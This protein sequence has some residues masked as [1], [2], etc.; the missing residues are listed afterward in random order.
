MGDSAARIA[1]VGMA[2]RFPGAANAE[3]FWANLIAGRESIERLTVEQMRPHEPDIDALMED[4]NFV[5]A[6]GMLDDIELFDAGFFG[7]SP[8]EAAVLDPQQRLWLETAWSALEQAGVDPQRFKGPIGVFAGAGNMEQ[9][10]LYNML[11]DR[12]GVENQVKLRTPEA[13]SAMISSGKDFLP[14]RTAYKFNLRGPAVNVQT[15]CSTAL[16]AVHMACQSLLAFESDLAIAGGVSIGFPQAQGYLAQ[17]GGIR[18]LDGHCRA[19]DEKA[20]GTVFSSGLGAFVLKRMEDAIDDGDEILAVVR[21]SALNNDGADKVSYGAPSPAGQAEV[22]AMAQAMADVHPDE[23]GYIEAHGTATPLG[24]PIE[25]EG[26]TRAWR[27]KSTATGAV[28]LG[29]VKSNVGHLDAAAGAAGLVKAVYALREGRLPATL[30]YQRP[31][32]RIDFDASPFR[33]VS[34]LTDW[35]AQASPD[36]LRLAGVS[37]FGVGGTNAHLIVEQAPER[38]AASPPIRASQLLVLSAKSATALARRCD[39]LADWL[40][41]NDNVELADVAWTLATGRAAMGFRTFVVAHSVAQAVDA[42]RATAKTALKRGPTEA[43][44][45]PLVFLFP[46]QGA[47]HPGMGRALYDTPGV[48]RD[49]VDRLAAYLQP[50]LELDIRDLLYPADEQADDQA[51]SDAAAAL[52]NTGVAQPALFVVQ[53]ALARLWESWGVRPQA[54]LGHSVGEYVAA[55]LAD[56][57]TEEQ[58]CRVLACRARFM[59]RMPG[60]SMLAIRRAEADMTPLLSDDIALAAVN[61]P[62]LCIVSGPDAA[63]DA[64]AE[65]LAADGEQSIRLHTSHAFHSAMMDGAL[66]PFEAVIAEHELGAPARPFV[67]CLTGDWITPEQA[68]DASY[69]SGQ[70]RQT[71]RFSPALGRLLEDPARIYIECGPSQNLTAAVRQH[72]KAGH[73]PVCIPS[74]AHAAS[75]EAADTALLS[76]L[77][78]LWQA[79]TTP[80]WAAVCGHARTPRQMLHLPTYP[81]ERQRYWIDP[82]ARQPRSDAAA[83]A[84]STVANAVPLQQTSVAVSASDKSV[85]APTRQAH[86]TELLR[87]L[88]L[89]L[90]G[91][92]IDAD[93]EATA[94]AALGMDSLFL[95]QAAAEISTRFDT[96]VRFRQLLDDIDSLTLLAT[97]LDTTLDADRFQP[98]PEQPSQDS[99]I[100][101]PALADAVASALPVPATASAAHGPGS[102]VHELVEQQ[103]DIMRRQLALLGG[104]ASA[105]HTNIASSGHGAGAGAADGPTIQAQVAQGSQGQNLAATAPGRFGPYKSINQDRDGGLTAVQQTFL[106][107]LIATLTAK[108]AKSKQASAAARKHLADPRGVAN[109]RRSWK[110]LVYQIVADRTDGARMVD[111]D[112]NAYVDI[113]MGFGVGFMGH[114]HP[115][116]VD[117][118]KAQIDKG[119]EVGPQTPLAPAV[120]EKFC[121]LVG[122]ERVTFCNTGSEAVMAALRCARTVTGRTKVVYFTGDYHGTFDEVLGRANIVKDQLT[123]RP[124]APGLAQ[125]S[126]DNVMVLDYGS[127]ASLDIVRAQADQIA[128]VLVEPVQSRYPDLQPDAFVRALRQITADAG[129]ALILDEVITGFRCALG[130]VKALWNIDADMCTYGKILGGGLP[131]GAMAGKAK[132]L[133]AIDGG[134]WQ[135]GDDSVPEAPMTF[136]AGTFVRHPLA[137]AAAD[138]VLDFLGADDGALQQDLNARTATFADEL[139]AFFET[140]GAPVRIRYFSSLFRFDLPHDQPFA[141]LMFYWMLA[142]DIYIREGAQNCFFSI[143]HTEADMQRVAEVVRSAVRALQDAGFL[144]AD[145]TAAPVAEPTPPVADESTRPA[146]RALAIGESIPLTEAQREIWLA[147]AVRPEIAHAFNEV[148]YFDLI[149]PLDEPSFARAVQQAVD[150]HEALSLRFAADGDSQTRVDIGA[151]PVEF[152]DLRDAPDPHAEALKAIQSMCG[153]DF[154]LTSADALLRVRVLRVAPERNLAALVVHHL[155]CDGWSAVVLFEDLAAIYSALAEDRPVDMTPAMAFSSY[156]RQQIERAPQ[157]QRQLD[158]WKRLYADPPAP[159]SLPTVGARDRDDGAPAGGR[160]HDLSPQLQAAVRESAARENVTPYAI[161]MAAYAVLLCRLAR[162]AEVVV[163]MPVAGQALEGHHALVGHCVQVLPLRI[164]CEPDALFS[165]VLK[166]VRESITQACVNA[167]CT[168]GSIVRALGHKRDPLRLPLAEVVF[169]FSPTGDPPRFAGL[170]GTLNEV[171]KTAV[172]FDLHF[173]LTQYGETL[174]LHCDYNAKVFD[175]ALIDGWIAAYETLLEAVTSNRDATVGGL[176]VSDAPSQ[177]AA[178]AQFNPAPLAV[179]ESIDL[180]GLIRQQ[181]KATPSAD[182]I[183]HAQGTWRYAE[184]DARSNAIAAALAARGVRPGDLVGLCLARTPALIAA[185]VGILKTGAAYVPMDPDYPLER[186]RYIARDSGIPMMLSHRDGPDVGVPVVDIDEAM[187]C[188]QTPPDIPVDAS[189]LAYIIY[190]SGSTG[191]PKGVRVRHRNVLALLA[192][193]RTAFTDDEIKGMLAAASVCF[194]FSVF[195]IF[196]PLTRGATVVLVDNL[197]SLMQSPPAPVTLISGVPSAMAELLAHVDLPAGAATICMGGE[198]LDRQLVARVQAQPDVRRVLDGYGPTETT[199]FATMAERDADGPQTIGRPIAGWRVYILDAQDQPVPVGTRGELAIGG[200][201]VTAGYIDRDELT[202]QRFVPDPFV[203]GDARMYRSGDLASW[204]ADGQIEY[205]GRADNQ[206]KVRG[207]RIELGE[208]EAVLQNHDGVARCVVM[209]RE[210]GPGDMQL[211]AYWQKTDTGDTADPAMLRRYLRDH[212]PL[213]MVPQQFV[214]MREWPSLAN[215]KLDRSRLQNPFERHR[216]DDSAQGAADAAATAQAIDGVTRIWAEVLGYEITPQPQDTFLDLGGHSLLAVRAAAAVKRDL[217]AD[218]PVRAMMLDSL[219]QLAARVNTQPAGSD[220]APAKD[221]HVPHEPAVAHASGQTQSRRGFAARLGFGKKA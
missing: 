149:G 77:G 105:P 195:E 112:G 13:F 23:I 141:Q 218:I 97:H 92:E 188:E 64:L 134:A 209:P 115:A 147:Q 3:D 94:F 180:A 48:F 129:T 45:A 73:S 84:P 117:A 26:L 2:G 7:F 49:T 171:A 178:H 56:V 161:Y 52:R 8:R 30:H 184:L 165:T 137:M 153:T 39:D 196:V 214:V 1:I 155:L 66:A 139:N 63:V 197:L 210:A 82:P 25:I 83:I 5:P 50:E 24:D 185:I 123:T 37:S 192:W 142:H 152:L 125:D 144:P 118:L 191:Q 136:F 127:Q 60:G 177:T 17:E 27:R 213:H 135:Y 93:N 75:D 79:G 208:I 204:R 18:S 29:S 85:A 9:Y 124:V 182:A 42:L 169:N 163:A 111:I 168:Y 10:L 59:A 173:N 175:G 22:I 74:Q 172:N 203:G 31:N 122:H 202:A 143:A 40:N 193:A 14:S 179:D 189:R 128:A 219:A 46:G 19:F 130:G 199:V 187:A 20:C 55:C 78:Q 33:V 76:A 103:L 121:R 116:V 43:D 21:G 110:E 81:F 145:A 120:A 100:A 159:L 190:T 58:A 113:T 69:W 34:Q 181:A 201:G 174:T 12:D 162:Q 102:P 57:F 41:A 216:G 198:A 220:A 68:V 4:P 90:S 183:A 89:E 211:V 71:V 148:C 44:E 61:G 119:F 36:K 62:S 99:P 194:D 98:R 72:S 157:A 91:I 108:T 109:F 133:D 6:R 106:D 205:A 87:A 206:I 67:S 96:R 131:I 138:A 200:A 186:L 16:A 151:V 160:L 156:A 170:T 167:D 70:L 47:Q 65:R 140:A 35:P 212:L 104:E 95:T 28:M 38:A 114:R 107:D 11:Q 158:Y 217:G 126:V 164:Q 176:P 166:R 146:E 15:A 221:S 86:I 32:P 54:M 88:F 154:D 215:G 101:D 80:D 132:W 53:L 51:D 150:R 207:F